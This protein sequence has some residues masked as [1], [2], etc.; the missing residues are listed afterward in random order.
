MPLQRLCSAG[1]GRT[2]C[3]AALPG[4]NLHSVPAGRSRHIDGAVTHKSFSDVCQ[5]NRMGGKRT[6]DAPQKNDETERRYSILT[7]YWS[8][9][10]MWML[11]W[12]ASSSQHRSEIH[13]ITAQLSNLVLCLIV[14]WHLWISIYWKRKSCYSFNSVEGAGEGLAPVAGFHHQHMAEQKLCR[15]SDLCPSVA[16]SCIPGNSRQ[17]CLGGFTNQSQIK[18]AMIW[19]T[20]AYDFLTSKTFFEA[21]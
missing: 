1:C 9:N 4:P 6:E 15:R 11:V 7:I 21:C 17:R 10:E 16:N 14:G 3:L 5:T 2:K 18:L 12:H 20:S 19:V 8:F 13:V